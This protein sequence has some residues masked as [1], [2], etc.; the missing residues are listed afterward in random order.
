MVIVSF[1]W[2]NVVKVPLAR[3]VFIVG[4]FEEMVVGDLVETG[5]KVLKVLVTFV[6]VVIVEVV[7]KVM[8]D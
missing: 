6:V 5:H 1:P 8:P 2:G 4:E 3:T 7:F